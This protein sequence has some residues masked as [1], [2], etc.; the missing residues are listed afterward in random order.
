[1]HIQKGNNR[2]N[3][4]PILFIV[5]ITICWIIGNSLMSSET[6]NGFSSTISDAILSFFDPNGHI[7]SHIFHVFIRKAA[8]FTEYAVLGIFLCI[9]ILRK[10]NTNDLQTIIVSLI[11]ALFIAAIDEFVQNFTGRSSMVKD[12]IID[13]CGA[14][15]GIL[16][17]C[18]F[19]SRRGQ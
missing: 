17:T 8:H 7:D 3:W 2:N 16:L 11:I 19:S 13:L 14:T 1:M 10:R 9:L 4:L 18:T 12:V 5:I 15:T 6:S